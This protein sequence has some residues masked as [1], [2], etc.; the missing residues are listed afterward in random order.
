LRTERTRRTAWLLAVATVLLVPSLGLIPFANLA[1]TFVSDHFLYLPSATLLGAAGWG[2]SAA[3]WRFARLAGA[4]ACAGCAAATLLYQP[5][6]R[7]GLSLWARV[8]TAAPD[9]YAGNL[10]LAEAL[11][12]VGRVP[13]AEARYARALELEPRVPDGY[14][15]YGRFLLERGDPRTATAQYERVLALDPDKVAG[16]VGAAECAARM[17]APE[18]ALEAYARAVALAPRDLP[19]RMGL[20]ATYLGYARPAHALPQFQAA[21]EVAPAHARAYLGAATSLRSLSRYAEAVTVLRAGLD[22]AGNDVA[23]LNMLALTLATAPDAS[24][25]DGTAAVSLAER[26]CA[27][28]PENYALGATLAA[29]YAEAGR[30]EDALRVAR[31]TETRAEAAGDERTA[32]EEH[33]R[34]AL[35]ARG[36]PLR[37]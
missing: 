9:S 1:L 18:R 30:F 3:P 5:T 13:E 17:G 27:A 34:A 14:L 28:A 36:E 2:W 7:D 31:D 20:G 24:V 23:L 19:A 8:V 35:Y 16:L 26:A 29:A 6:F 4:V 15:L 22:R 32:A 25:R 21:I 12:G 33:R 11:A 37:I 10:G